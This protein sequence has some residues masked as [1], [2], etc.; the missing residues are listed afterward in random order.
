MK[1]CKECEEHK[2]EEQFARTGKWLRNT[3][4]VCH[5]KKMKVRYQNDEEYRMKMNVKSRANSKRDHDSTRTSFFTVYRVPS[6]NY[7]G[8]TNNLK[9]RL[10]THRDRGRDTEGT[11]VLATF[12]CPMQAAMYEL[13]QHMGGAKGFHYTPTTKR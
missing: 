10:K 5:N 13:K 7:V 8:M 12:A 6:D 9:Q 2:N 11:E 4:R 3:C 1:K